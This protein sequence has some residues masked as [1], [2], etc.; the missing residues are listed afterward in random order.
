MAGRLIAL[1]L[2]LG[3]VAVTAAALGLGASRVEPVPA[4]APVSVREEAQPQV[5]HSKTTFDATAPAEDDEAGLRRW[6][7]GMVDLDRDALRSYAIGDPRP[8]VAGRAVQE[9][10][11]RGEVA[12]DM[13]LRKLVDDPRPRIR[14][15]SVRAL[16]LAQDRRV[17]PDLVRV[18][19]AGPDDVRLLALQALGR[20]GGPEA[21]EFL[22]GVV[23][24]GQREERAFATLAL[25]ELDRRRPVVMEPVRRK[26]GQ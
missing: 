18:A 12:R 5:V 6:L 9:L 11:R 21:Q 1:G 16:G 4:G 2:G 25:R 7:L 3:V 20:V 24:D 22:E 8:L 14:Q 10:G 19:S 26:P 13:D 17:V 15:E 23:E